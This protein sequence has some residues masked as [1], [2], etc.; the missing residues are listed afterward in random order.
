MNPQNTTTPGWPPANMGNTIRMYHDPEDEEEQ[1]PTTVD[2]TM[3]RDFIESTPLLL[4]N[5]C[6]CIVVDGR[7]AIFYAAFVAD[8]GTDVV[9]FKDARREYRSGNDNGGGRW[10]Y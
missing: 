2:F 1:D 5:V 9:T 10:V 3:N 7:Y 4:L 8:K 6:F